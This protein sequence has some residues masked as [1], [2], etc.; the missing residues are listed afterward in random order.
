[1]ND[2]T[3][4]KCG[5][6]ISYFYLNNDIDTNSVSIKHKIREK[7]FNTKTNLIEHNIMLFLVSGKIKICIN[8]FPEYISNSNTIIFIPRKVIFDIHYIETSEVFTAEFG[9]LYHIYSKK[10]FM[11]LAEVKKQKYP[12]PCIPINDII[13]EYLN[14]VRKFITNPLHKGYKCEVYEEE[15]FIT[16]GVYYTKAELTQLF[17]PILDN[18]ELIRQ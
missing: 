4:V 3:S 10:L 7:G 1:M 17:F 18:P 5:K 6:F 8:G 13:H 11:M 9:N 15:F 2:I 12:F 14:D 16:F